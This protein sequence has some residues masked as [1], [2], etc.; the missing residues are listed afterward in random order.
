MFDDRH[1]KLSIIMKK[2]LC[3]CNIPLDKCIKLIIINNTYLCNECCNKIIDIDKFII[4]N[5]NEIYKD[6]ILLMN[7]IKTIFE[8]FEDFEDFDELDI[9]YDKIIMMLIYV[10]NY[11]SLYKALTFFI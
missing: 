10:F 4:K 7:Y 3:K 6:K 1:I 5:I 2:Y 11:S 9:D 8:D